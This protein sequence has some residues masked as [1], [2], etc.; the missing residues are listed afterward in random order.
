M[1]SLEN[2][3]FDIRVLILETLA[4]IETLSSL[5]IASRKFHDVF[6]VFPDRILSR[7]YR[8][9]IRMYMLES[10]YIAGYGE[11]LSSYELELADHHGDVPKHLASVPAT[12]T[13]KE[14]IVRAIYRLWVIK[15]LWIPRK[16]W[17]GSRGPIIEDAF[18]LFDSWGFWE[19]MAVKAVIDFLWDHVSNFFDRTQSQDYL[20]EARNMAGEDIPALKEDL[21]N[22]LESLCVSDSRK[23]LYLGSSVVPSQEVM[24]IA[25]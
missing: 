15:L 24:R 5:I 2:L 17:E 23:I 8:K 1:R 20:D 4:D 9:E 16:Y 13:E 7:V 12:S 3:D 11:R 22:I 18:F 21:K 14:R 6:R 19:F 25:S 10:F